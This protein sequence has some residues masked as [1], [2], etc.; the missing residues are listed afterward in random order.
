MLFKSEY[1]K[2]TSR[3][4]YDEVDDNG[5]FMLYVLKVKD[6]YRDKGIG[7]KIIQEIKDFCNEHGLVLTL[8]PST[9][10]GSNLRRL[11]RFYGRCGMVPSYK[12]QKDLRK[13]YNRDHMYFLPS[14]PA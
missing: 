2:F 8:K 14:V 1:K 4:T 5:N 7:T 13:L 9:L 11:R 3:L 6:R 10:Y 12:V